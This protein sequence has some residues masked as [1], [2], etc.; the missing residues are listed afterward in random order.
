MVGNLSINL[1]REIDSQLEGQ[2]V[3]T[4]LELESQISRKVDGNLSGR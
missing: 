1:V 2:L 3:V 4:E